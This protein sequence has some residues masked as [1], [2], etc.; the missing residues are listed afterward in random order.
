MPAPPIGTDLAHAAA[1]LAAG[2]LVAFGTETVYGLGANALDPDAVARV[3]EAKGRPSFDPL[4]VHVADPDDVGR[5]AASRPAIADELI[6]RFWPGPLTLVLPKRPEIPDLVTSGLP[7]VAVRCPGAEPARDLI[8]A[9]G[10]PVA[11]PSANPFG[12]VS[13][14]TAAHVRDGL[15]DR[16]DY[17]LDTGPCGVGVESTV[18]AFDG[19]TPVLLRP[20]GLPRE[21]LAAVAGE[22]LDPTDE[23]GPADR[24]RP[25][26]GTLDRHYAPRCPL[27]VVAP[28]TLSA[29]SR[30]Q[31]TGQRLGVLTFSAPP[32]PGAVASEILSPAADPREAARNLFAALR[33]LDTAG[34][35]RILAERAPDEGLGV[36]I[37]DRLRRA[38]R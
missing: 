6:G 3:F 29:S 35:D 7:T 23:A 32:P 2:K 13:P 33:R 31:P 5:V 15:G 12:G 8:R 10:V 26:P 4:I 21:D 18:V 37:N 20:G 1:L 24:P 27:E 34:V 28:G 38:A 30:R 36:A 25:S 19:E 16:V 17:I 11:A 9:A 22:V 14:T